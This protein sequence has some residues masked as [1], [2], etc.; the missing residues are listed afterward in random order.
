MIDYFIPVLPL[1][2][3]HVKLCLQRYVSKFS[4]SKHPKVIE[5][6]L[7]T[8]PFEEDTNMFATSG[9]KKLEARVAAEM[10]TEL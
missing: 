10:H 9:C 1:E 4:S 2:Q 8:V 7:K 3:R 5:K 6:I